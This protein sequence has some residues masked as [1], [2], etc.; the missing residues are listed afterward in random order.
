MKNTKDVL[1]ILPSNIKSVI[2]DIKGLDTLQEIRLKVDKPLILQLGNEEVITGVIVSVQ[3]IKLIIQHISN[4]SIYAF[5]EEIKQGYITIKGGHRVG[6]CGSCVIENNKIKTI[7]SIG[8]INIRVCKEVE[9]CS[10]NLMPYIVKDNKLM[11]TIIISPPR[12]GKTT[13]IRDIARNLSDG[14]KKINFKGKKVCIIDERSEISGCYNGIPQMNVGVRTD[15][16]D[17]CPKAEGI[18]MAIRSMSPE[19]IV[20]DE[21]GTHKDMESIIMALNSGI[22]LI[23]TIHGYGIEDL[24]NRL[25]FKEIVENHVF[26]RA[27][28]L[29][30]RY[31]AGTIEYVYDFEKKEELWRG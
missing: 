14:I 6:L 16:L 10:D 3:D 9:G 21:I 22:N 26:R 27:V 23:T 30:T 12:C 17:N 28:V 7:K 29:S 1:D 2:K 5:E 19:A 18:M 4:Y 31:G 25:V 15:V 11:N 20:C 13:L 24:F 8:S